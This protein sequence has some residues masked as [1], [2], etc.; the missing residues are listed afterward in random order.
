MKGESFTFTFDY[1]TIQIDFNHFLWE[2]FREI[3]TLKNPNELDLLLI[4]SFVIWILWFLTLNLNWN[5]KILL[6]DCTEWLQSFLEKSFQGNLLFNSKLI[7]IKFD[8]DGWL[9]VQS[10][11]GKFPEKI[12]YRINLVQRFQINHFIFLYSGFQPSRNKKTFKL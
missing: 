1:C 4:L 5:R 2:S 6:I 9:V 10:F 7:W 3:K 11:S 8:F 12:I